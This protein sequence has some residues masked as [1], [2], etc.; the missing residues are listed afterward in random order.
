M[1][2]AFTFVP[3]PE[4]PVFYPTSEEFEDP[5]A[6]LM[7]IRPIC[8]KT[9]ICKIVPPKCW[10]PPFAVNM[11]EF[12]FTPRVQR[13]YELEAHSRIKLN[14][15]SKLYKFVQLQGGDKI[16]VPSICGRY[17]DL[18][19]LHKQVAE[20]GGYRQACD[21]HSW[22]NIAEKL[23]YQSRHA[24]SIR[25]NYEKLLLSFD[26]TVSAP[27]SSTKTVNRS[28]SRISSYKR[29]RRSVEENKI[30][31]SAS[32][33]LKNLQFFGAGPKAAVPVDERPKNFKPEI[34][35]DDYNCRVCGSGD[36]E[37]SLLVCDTDTCEACYHLYCLDPPLRSIPKCQWK[38]PECVRQIC[39]N[40]VDVYGFP[41]SSKTYSL[42]EFGIMADEFKSA[43]FKRPCTEVPCAEVEQEFWRI[44]QEYNDD[45]VVEYGADIHSS[46]QGSGFP[47]KLML[48]NLVGTASQLAEAK[49]YAESP[50]NLNIL[51][52]LN[53]SVLRFIKGNIDGMKIPWCYVGMVFS[54]FCWHIED[55]WSY[56]INF[57]HWGEPK[58]WYGVSRL[59]ADDFERAMRKHASELFDQAPDLLHHI[60]TNVNPNILQAEG[61]PIYRTDQHCGEFVVT[62]PRAYHAGF[63]QG[64]NFAE[65]VNICLPDWLPIGRACIEHYAEIKRHCV[66][67]N[68]ELLCTLAEVAVGNVLPEDVLTITNPIT[69]SSSVHEDPDNLTSDIREKLPPGCSTSGLD[70]GAVAIVHQE[71]TA[72]LKEERRLR[73]LVSKNG[74]TNSKKVRFD[75][76]PDDARVCDFCLTTLF[77]SGVSCSCVEESNTIK[78]NIGSTSDHSSNSPNPTT[79]KR[80]ISDQLSMNESSE[81]ERRPPSHMVCLKH[82]S[83]LCDKCPHSVFVLNYHYS[84]DELSNL[85][86]CLAERLAHFYSWKNQLSVLIQPNDSSS[87]NNHFIKKEPVDKQDTTSDTQSNNS[88][89]N[90]ITLEEL[91][92]KLTEGYTAGYHT[93]EIYDEAQSMLD[94]GKHLQQICARLKSSIIGT[95]N[96]N[97]FRNPSIPLSSS[98]I[99]AVRFQ[100]RRPATFSVATS[101]NNTCPTSTRIIKVPS[102]QGYVVLNHELDVNNPREYDMIRLIEACEQ[103]HPLNLFEDS[104]VQ[105]IKRLLNQLTIWQQS[106]RDTINLLCNLILMNATRSISTTFSLSDH[107]T[108]TGLSSDYLSKN[109]HLLSADDQAL[110]LLDYLLEELRSEFPVYVYRIPEWNSL[111]LLRHALR[112]L[113]VCSRYDNTTKCIHWSL[114]HLR[115]YLA[116]GEEIISQLTA[117]TSCSHK[118]HSRGS[119]ISTPSGTL[120]VWTNQ[121]AAQSLVTGI[122]ASGVDTALTQILRFMLARMHT[123]LGKLTQLSVQAETLISNLTE[124]LNSSGNLFQIMMSSTYQEIESILSQFKNLGI[125]HLTAINRQI[126]LPDEPQLHTA[127]DE[128]SFCSI[129]DI[130]SVTSSEDVIQLKA[131][132]KQRIDNMINCCTREGCSLSTKHPQ[133]T[134]AEIICDLG[135]FFSSSSTSDHV[136]NL[137]TTN[138]KIVVLSDIF[139]RHLT[140]LNELVSNTKRAIQDLYCKVYPHRLSS[141]DIHMD[142]LLEILL[143]IISTTNQKCLTVQSF[144]DTCLSGCE[145]ASSVY[146]QQS[147]DNLQ[148]ISSTLENMFTTGTSCDICSKRFR[149]SKIIMNQDSSENS[150]ITSCSLCS[151]FVED[152]SV[153]PTFDWFVNFERFWSI[154]VSSHLNN[155][156][157]IDLTKE[158]DDRTYGSLL[159]LDNPVSFALR[160]CLDQIRE[161]FVELKQLLQVNE[162]QLNG[163]FSTINKSLME[164]LPNCLINFVKHEK[165]IS[166][167][168]NDDV[169][170][171]YNSSDFIYKLNKIFCI[172]LTF[173]MNLIPYIEF[174]EYILASLLNK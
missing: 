38:C 137:V 147:K 45:V 44:L 125:D 24:H 142:S 20:A 126:V 58:T 103:Q 37:A 22:P 161:H 59:H 105:L 139:S 130:Q 63:N 49:K 71:F 132:V 30:D 76:M 101:S 138:Q 152:S 14:F 91:Q 19:A 1:P 81:E 67:S 158:E 119:H 149:I 98:T 95:G 116:L 5:L 74:V 46:S 11:K 170:S 114:L 169:A 150:L 127:L 83:E 16:R 106:A 66:F 167:D 163:I 136:L 157:V 100:T 78:E 90:T 166:Y 155:E 42:Q 75:E 87:L 164:Q 160:F 117:N 69:P 39:S 123:S 3:P 10:N 82:V 18:Y 70:I 77:L 174:I 17:L 108:N 53:R 54:S 86:Q 124:I 133:L 165:S 92:M 140:K 97:R 36:D 72:V 148:Y 12:S 88:T 41:Q 25:S 118:P 173:K 60:T 146:Q 171:I 122:N 159:L 141:H 47:T 55:H 84:I 57:N 4:A 99:E 61:V 79:R 94:R 102:N 52:L 9:G 65:A 8:I 168:D 40:P 112:W 143:P 35:I 23:G 13:L 34:N 120:H 128:R 80:G 156:E 135:A 115:Y 27:S 6:Y 131:L 154:S 162:N 32:N 28:R 111:D 48:K 96:C 172:L 107:L 50:W 64:F 56:S 110:L 62:F 104:S 43:Y 85:E 93:D 134:E 113:C 129:L 145:N 144:K 68:D 33:E 29:C 21:N 2:N 151:L 73:E 121:T 153:Y 26:Q 31:Y 51:P 15:I 109:F 7:K 89:L